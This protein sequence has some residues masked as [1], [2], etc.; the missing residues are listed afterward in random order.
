VTLTL[1]WTA[2]MAA[3]PRER[4]IPDVIYRHDRDRDGNDLVPVDRHT[5]PA[6]WS[7]MVAADEPVYTQVD[8][9]NPA[10]DGT[11]FEVTSSCSDRRVVREMLEL[12]AP[13]QGDRVLEIGTGTGWNAA[14]L[15]EAGATVTT[16]EIDA[17]LARHARKRLAANG[18][19]QVR[20][21][22][23]DGADITTCDADR[24]IST[25]GT[26]ETPWSWVEQ[27]RPGGRL[28]VPLN[29]DWYPPGLAV[30]ERTDNGAVG[31][32]AGPASFMRMRAQARS[33]V[34]PPTDLEPAHLGTTDIYPYHLAGDRDAA[35]A[36]GQRTSGITFTWRSP[37]DNEDGV[38]WLYATGSWAIVDAS[39][40]P[41][42]EV[43]Q[44]GPRK[45][46][47]EVIAA[48]R[49][50]QDAG[51]PTVADWLVTV[52]GRGQRIELEA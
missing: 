10:A 15:A 52:D 27:C 28:V 30:L 34:V 11:G 47:D 39:T 46:H 8:N 4:F 31:R 42:Y 41:P 17:A 49:W 51:E 9:G 2:V 38:L 22:H 48:Y 5:D 19:G 24:V 21:V 16:V 14:L 18:Y 20:V 45:L 33:R 26:V 25:V 40:A 37:D 12:L 13:A 43:K 32:L 7:A 6:N 44:A 35:V 1:D 3:V 50:W 23:A 36:I 29:G